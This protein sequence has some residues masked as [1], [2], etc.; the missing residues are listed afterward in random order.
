MEQ[1][2][3]NPFGIWLRRPVLCSALA[4]LPML[5]TAHPGY[6]IG[7]MTADRGGATALVFVVILFS[8]ALSFLLYRKKSDRIPPPQMVGLLWSYGN[9]PFVMAFVLLI[10]GAA[11]WSFLVAAVAT[12]IHLGCIAWVAPKLRTARTESDP[13]T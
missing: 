8:G 10:F 3:S 9:L 2:A 7:T 12:G 11:T 5:L 1:N 6:L 13:T 4:F